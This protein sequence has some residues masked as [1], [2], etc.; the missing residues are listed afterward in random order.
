MKFTAKQIA[1]ALDGKVDGNPE[2]E[3]SNLSKIEEGKAGTLSFLANPKYASYIYETKASIVIV[4][5]NFVPEKPIKATLIRVKDAYSS[6]ASLLE[7]Y[8]QAK[9]KRTGISKASLY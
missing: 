1:E 9:F 6:F 8:Q 7:L 2:I 3:V 4:N 5:E